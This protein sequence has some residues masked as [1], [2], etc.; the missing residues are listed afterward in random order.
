[1]LGWG[2]RDDHHRRTLR[3]QIDEV[4]L[5][6]ID[7]AHDAPDVDVLDRLIKLNRAGTGEGHEDVW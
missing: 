5:N 1:L 2:E 3:R 6:E 7:L 4:L